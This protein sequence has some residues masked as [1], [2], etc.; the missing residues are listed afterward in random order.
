MCA[1]TPWNDA[2]RGRR[3][4]VT[5]HTGFKGSWL[6]VWLRELGAE[7][8]G[9]S[10]GPP[11]NPA[12]FTQA[13]IG[14]FVTDVRGD[15]RDFTHLSAVWR[16]FKPDVVFN[17]AAQS[18]VRTSYQL[19]LDTITTN[20]LGTVHVMEVARTID[21]PVALVL[22][23]SD[24]CYENRELER[25]YAEEDTLGGRDV[26]SGSK[27]AAELLISSYRRSFFMG[28]DRIPIA[29][30]RAGNVIGGGD[31][32]SDRIVPDVVR[33]LQCAK[34]VEVRNPRATRPWQHVLE[35]LSGYLQLGA[36]LL[37]DNNGAMRTA[38]NFGPIADN[39]RTVE[40]LVSLAI[41]RWGTGEWRDV[42]TQEAPHEA[43]L[44]SLDITRATRLLGWRPR[45]NFEEAV[46]KTI[47]WYAR[48]GRGDSAFDACRD[49]ITAY[50][51][52]TKRGV[53]SV[54]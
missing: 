35:P 17:L 8:L 45:W 42:S 51:T 12:L 52:H 29:S 9:Y 48:V 31:W 36:Q 41:A 32:A 28:D 43:T 5:G 33:A 11:T 47:D 6:S 37:A 16:E 18:I 44:L 15:I 10:L 2:Y 30:A 24:K 1:S 23:T 38:F 13:A 27:A 22:I 46:A 39:T 26:Y 21:K 19:P 3:V 4:L 7:V 50:E 34:A 53:A 54:A 25:G 49:Q 20:V 14:R 40:E